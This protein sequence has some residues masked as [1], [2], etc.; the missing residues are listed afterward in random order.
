MSTQPVIGKDR[1]YKPPSSSI[2]KH[3]LM[4]KHLADREKAFRVIFTNDNTRML[5][6]AEAIAIIRWKPILCQQKDLF[7]TLALP[8]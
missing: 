7:L 3:L 6:I 5:K 2:A 4:K 8:C 1:A